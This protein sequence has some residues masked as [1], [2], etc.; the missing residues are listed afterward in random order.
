MKT[1]VKNKIRKRK[2]GAGGGA[3]YIRP[4]ARWINTLCKQMEG[5]GIKST[6]APAKRDCGDVDKRECGN[7]D[8]W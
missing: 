5:G 4:R 6:E 2:E 3:S 7:A 8:W 1:F